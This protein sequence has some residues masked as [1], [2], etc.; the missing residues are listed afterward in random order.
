MRGP[1]IYAK[2]RLAGRFRGAAPA[3][4]YGLADLVRQWYRIGMAWL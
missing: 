2:M 1:T 3:P 4:T